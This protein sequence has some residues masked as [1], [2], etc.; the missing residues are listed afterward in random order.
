M[1]TANLTALA[2]AA[3]A[4]A[5]WPAR[6]GAPLWVNRTPTEFNALLDADGDGDLDAV[7]ADRA[8][9]ILRVGRRTGTTTFKWET[10]VQGGVAP[11]DGL[12]AGAVVTNTRQAVALAGMLAN[13]VTLVD[14][15][16]ASAAL[17]PKPLFPCHAGLRHA[18]PRLAAALDALPASDGDELFLTTDLNGGTSGSHRQLFRRA[19]DGTMDEDDYSAGGTYPSFCAAIAATNNAVPRVA[20]LVPS[21]DRIWLF[22]VSTN[23]ATLGPYQS[24]GVIETTQFVYGFFAPG[25]AYGQF[26]LYAPGTASARR[27][28]LQAD[29]TYGAAFGP[30]SSYTLPAVPWHLAPGPATN[31]VTLVATNG[32]AS[33]YTYNGT[34]LTLVNALAL[35]EGTTGAFQSSLTDPSTGYTLMLLD[36]DGDGRSDQSCRYG[37]SGGQYVALASPV[38]LT[39]LANREARPNSLAFVGEPL[40]ATN[41]TRVAAYTASDWSTSKSG[42]TPSATLYGASDRGESLGLNT[43]SAA[44]TVSGVPADATHIMIDQ[45][46]TDIG[47]QPLFA[48]AGES[49]SAV[50]IDPNGGTFDNAVSV[51]LTAPA[52]VSRVLYRLAATDLWTE[53]IGSSV[54]LWLFKAT[55]LQCFGF[56]NDNDR[57]TPIASAAFAFTRSPEEQDSDGDGVPDF[58]ELQLGLDPTAGQDDDDDGLSDLDELLGGTKP[59]DADS[60]NDTF[61]DR[62]ERAAGTNPNSTNSVPTEAQIL[63]GDV[64]ANERLAVYD[65]RLGPTPYDG[66]LLYNSV[67]AT[68]VPCLVTALDGSLL[69]TAGTAWNG[70]PGIQN[71]SLSFRGLPAPFEGLL[72]GFT[73]PAHF[74]IATTNADKTIGRELVKLVAA[75]PVP[76]I[77]VSYVWQGGSQAAEAAA[78]TNAARTAYTNATRVT[79][80]DSANY[81]DTLAAAL[82]EAFAARELSA[83]GLFATNALSLFPA[84]AE[85]AALPHPTADQLL[86]LQTADAGVRPA[87]GLTNTLG[88]L[89]RSCQTNTHAQVIALRNL[90]TSVYRYACTQMNGAP[91]LYPL[92]LDALRQVIRSG[93]VPGGYTNHI[94]AATAATAKLGAD[95]LLGL[96]PARVR[97]EVDV[98]AGGAQLPDTTVLTD[99]SSLQRYSLV[100]PDGDAFG[101]TL[102]LAV[103]SNSTIHVDG[104]LNGP[105]RRR[106]ADFEVEVISITVTALPAPSPID[107][108]ANL[109]PDAYELLVFGSSGAA[110]DRDLDGDGYGDLQEY[111][112]DTDPTSTN[113][114]PAV[115]AAPVGVPVVAISVE[116]AY[117]EVSW[118]C[119][120][121]YQNRFAFTLETTADLQHTP[122][123]THSTAT[124]AGVGDTLRCEL[125]LPPEG[126]KRFYRVRAAL[127]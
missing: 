14:L 99:P 93:T 101:L 18:G 29:A 61:T 117:L 105:D 68:N 65:L 60:D 20:V 92:P 79:V 46:T 126:P 76:P 23:A 1:K 37:L 42:V 100:E 122:F 108:S 19:P 111:L 83:R 84:R 50:R 43:S 119:P 27:I 110:P 15:S 75:P 72:A 81:Y 30:S 13:R 124:P 113:S 32:S 16:S 41:A 120:S 26:L 71:P 28:A 87:Y 64:T 48:A 85:P 39:S 3:L 80:S 102:A 47:V 44:I 54:T 63:A 57:T 73:T 31:E 62:E 90:T 94:T 103:P 49:V 52:S 107:Q 116:G 36:T 104:F 7:V 11:L 82:F 74:D 127:R 109:L 106:G 69:G 2:L 112:E 67:C 34:T 24:V 115:A 21:S 91:G 70:F 22:G 125:Q 12:A 9:G 8:T 35:P 97:V 98:L 33:V 88:W 10:P 40:V 45:L 86:A 51:T 55:T 78:W 121:R 25:A 96:I 5:A 118:A 6:A 17:V 58:V 66:F 53:H 77:N 114:F 89:R 4:L 95:R 38:A 56:N 123:V 59:N